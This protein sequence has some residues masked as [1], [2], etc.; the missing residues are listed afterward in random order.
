ML[1]TSTHAMNTSGCR[2]AFAAHLLITRRALADNET[3]VE[4]IRQ[5]V[6]GLEASGAALEQWPLPK[7]CA[8]LVPPLLQRQARALGSHLLILFWSQPYLRCWYRRGALISSC[9]LA[10]VAACEVR[11]GQQRRAVPGELCSA[12]CVCMLL[13]ARRRIS[14]FDA[15]GGRAHMAQPGSGAHRGVP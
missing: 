12:A 11:C 15:H 10:G 4:V 3:D 1:L 13:V 2:P 14:R 8:L 5:D 9:R 7:E 6:G